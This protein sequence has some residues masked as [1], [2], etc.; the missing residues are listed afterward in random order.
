MTDWTEETKTTIDWTEGELTEMTFK[1]MG[2]LTFVG[3][4][5]QTFALWVGK[6]LPP[7]YTEETKG[8][9]SYDKET[10]GTISYD[11]ETK[12]TISWDEESK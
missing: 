5:E 10:K 7:D 3:L 4:G 6:F 12:T 9:M 11:E 2:E 1:M 8:T